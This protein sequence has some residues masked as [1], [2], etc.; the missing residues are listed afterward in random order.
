MSSKHAQE[1]LGQRNNTFYRII[2]E[3]EGNN[4]KM[5]LLSRRKFSNVYNDDASQIVGL[6]KYINF[7]I[8][9]T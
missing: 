1:L 5:K 4:K 2:N 7:M 8:L 3:F 6:Q 9:K